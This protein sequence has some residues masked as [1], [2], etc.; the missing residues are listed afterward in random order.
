MQPIPGGAGQVALV[1]GS[2]S[3]LA[4][5]I[6][7]I[8]GS[9]CPHI[10]VLTGDNKCVS[11]DPDGVH[12]KTLDEFGVMVPSKLVLNPGQVEKIVAFADS[13]VGKP[14]AFADDALIALER[15]FRFRF[16]RWLR[17]KFQNDGQWQCAQLSQQSL[18]AG[19]VALVPNAMV[20]DVYPGTFE[21]AF[22][23]L[24]WYTLAF[25]KSFKLSWHK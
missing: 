17:R 4:F 7:R 25:F 9:H 13:Q 19:G 5:L 14:Y 18:L 15:V 11:A 10:V 12:Y 22:I 21:A 1:P 3:I 8:T 16:P 6:C 2:S 24:G 23:H 20:G